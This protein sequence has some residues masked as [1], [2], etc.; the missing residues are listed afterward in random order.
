MGSTIRTK[1]IN[2]Q[3]YLYEITYYYDPASKRTRQQSRYLGKSVDGEPVRV[4]DANRIPRLTFA[5]GE[6]LPLLAILDALH[7][8]TLLSEH[9]PGAKVQALLTLALNRV[10]SPLPLSQ[11]ESW[12]E[13]TVE[14][15]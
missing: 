11:I 6:Y 8:E 10:I 4:R 9:I 13:G 7:L 12:W 1:I 2:G 3:E 14:G 15:G 5:Y